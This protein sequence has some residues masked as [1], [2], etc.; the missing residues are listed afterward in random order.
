MLMVLYVS[1]QHTGEYT[2]DRY[3]TICSS[4]IDGVVCIC[5][6][7][8]WVHTWLILFTFLFICT[9]D[10]QNHTLLVYSSIQHTIEYMNDCTLYRL[11]HIHVDPSPIGVQKHVSPKQS[12]TSLTGGCD[13]WLYRSRNHISTGD[14][15]N[16]MGGLGSHQ[17][18][19]ILHVLSQNLDFQ[20]HMSLFDVQWFEVSSGCSVWWIIDHHCFHGIRAYA[21]SLLCMCTRLTF[22]HI[23][24]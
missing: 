23:P 21:S 22:N 11:V 2:C 4:Y 15:I 8:W 7:H 6:A 12:T 3:Y 16:Q 19:T 14:E 20:R 10:E 5:T 13:L 9:T 18:A 24:D 1:V 17:P